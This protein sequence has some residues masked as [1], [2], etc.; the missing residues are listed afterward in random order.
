MIAEKFLVRHFSSSQQALEEGDL[1]NA[2]VLPGTGILL[3]ARPKCG[4]TWPP[5][6]TSGVWLLQTWVFTTSSRGGLG[7]VSGPWGALELTLHAHIQAQMG[8]SLRARWAG[9][10]GKSVQAN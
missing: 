2:Y 10:G 1:E 5:T 4:A 9:M 6:V 7:G 3:T 8:R